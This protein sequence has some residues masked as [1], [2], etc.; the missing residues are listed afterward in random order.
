MVRPR[1]PARARFRLAHRLFRGVPLTTNGAAK[2]SRR[3]AGVFAK[4]ILFRL[5]PRLFLGALL[6]TN[7]AAKASRRPAGVFAKAKRFLF[8][9]V[10][11]V[12]SK[13]G[14]LGLTILQP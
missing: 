12:S 1:T 3:P 13:G 4:G 2:A 11:C 6:A 9:F 8:C 7:G 10:S 5:A 14:A